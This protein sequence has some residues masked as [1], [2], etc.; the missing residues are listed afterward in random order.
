M[1]KKQFG[2]I[3]RLAHSPSRDVHA[4]LLEKL[5][6]ADSFPAPAEPGERNGHAAAYRRLLHISEQLPVQGPLTDHPDLL[7]ALLEYAALTDPALFYALFI[8]HCQTIGAI[9]TLCQGRDDLSDVLDK[10]VAAE[11]IGAFATTEVGRGRS[12]YALRT[13]AV[14]DLAAHEFVLTTPDA[15]AAKISSATVGGDFPR[16]GVVS[17]RLQVIG[18]DWGTAMFLVPLSD[19]DGPC[20][21]VRIKARA[22]ASGTAPGSALISFDAVRIPF[23]FWLRDAAPDAVDATLTML[24]TRA[25]DLNML[26]VVRSGWE[27]AVVALAAV[28]RAAASTALRYAD[29]RTTYDPRAGKGPV[30]V[31][32]YRHQRRALFGALSTAYVL[33]ALAKSV[34]AAST[35]DLTPALIR[36]Q[37]LLKATATRMA[38]GVLQRS[39]AACG[40]QGFVDD[41]RL[42]QYE[43]F[44][45]T[46]GCVAGDNQLLR[47]DGA[48]RLVEDPDYPP[49]PLDSGPSEPGNLSDPA[50]WTRLARLRERGLYEEFTAAVRNAQEKGKSAADAWNDHLDLGEALAESHAA[51]LVTEIVVQA[52]ASVG[53]PETKALAQDLYGLHFLEEL[54][55]HAAWYLTEGV[56][57]A[58]EVRGVRTHLHDICERLAPHAAELA[59]A[60][61]VPHAV[62]RAPI[63]D[64]DYVT[65]LMGRISPDAPAAD[66]AMTDSQPA[67]EDTAAP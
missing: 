19:A 51:S 30:P 61:D 5:F 26:A 22:I 60:L 46:F 58:D 14:Y 42:L 8:H 66:E 43:L 35:Q 56:L 28:S 47:F 57:T 40:A 31:L 45:R 16:L 59:E 4:P 15:A 38:E 13:E 62:V 36:T 33:S 41:N 37:S 21:K 49:P 53:D 50:T 27:A 10:L 67:Q 29:Q 65:A 12:N 2:A 24:N 44:A 9:Q 54:H 6:T 18:R 3:G 64:D 39:R 7:F 55:H 17:A 20:D 11:V 63:A 25:G 34:T 1:H 52:L 48:S 23:R 32:A